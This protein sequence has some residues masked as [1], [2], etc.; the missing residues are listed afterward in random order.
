MGGEVIMPNIMLTYRCNLKCPYCFANEFVN[1]KNTDI[2]LENFEKALDFIATDGSGRVGLIGGEPLIHD[3]FKDII[4]KLIYDNRFERIVIYTNGLLI[5]KYINQLV[6]PKTTFLVNCNSP[7]DIGE[8]NSKHLINNL[9]IL[10]KGYYMKNRVNL[11]I[12]LYDIDKDYTYIMELLKR[13][14]LHKLRI[15]ITVPDFTKNDNVN[16]IEYFKSKKQFILKFLKDMDT[17]QVVPYYD[18]NKPPM[19][20]WTEEESEWIKEY[21]QKYTTEESTLYGSHSFCQ[22]V[23]D[24]LP[25]LS[26]VRCFGMSDFEKVKIDNFKCASDLRYY[27][28]GLIDECAYKFSAETECKECYERKIQKCSA[29]CMGFK[30]EKIKKINQ[31]ILNERL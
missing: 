2:S 21:V 13:Y 10:Y 23:I 22:P 18:C 11:G 12:N 16:I 1:K 17:I 9:D 15:S 28:I 8:N 30:S 31:Y 27:F 5:D 20:I 7:D 24:I 6:H 29:G 3:K 19:C 14:H 26:A 4:E 25:D